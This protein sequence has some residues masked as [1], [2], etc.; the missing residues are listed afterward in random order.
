MYI[1]SAQRFAEVP[2]LT[3]E[4]KEALDAFDALCTD[5]RLRFDMDF[6]FGDMQF[7]NNY[8]T[9]H[10]RTGY[11]DF[12]E[13]DR[14]RHLLRLWLFTA[15]LFDIPEA[16]RMRYRDMDAWQKNPRAPIYKFE[17]IMNVSTH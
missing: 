11:E 8:V 14:K 15:G 2:R 16:L 13:P 4:Q 17:D 6:R 10:S 3:A 5:P 1:E 9:L 12:P 7:L